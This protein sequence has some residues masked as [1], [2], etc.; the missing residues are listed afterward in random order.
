[1]KMK[2]IGAQ[3]STSRRNL[4]LGMFLIT[5]SM[6][7]V[8][9]VIDANN[10]TEEFLVAAKPATSGSI[11]TE[12]SFRIARMNLGESSRLYL[13]PGDLE[14]GNYLLNTMAVGQLVAL[15]SVASAVIDARQPVVISSTMP[16]PQGVGVGDFVDI[17]VSE[18]QEGGVFA[19]PMTLV[20]DAEIVDIAQATGV[21][22][23]QQPQVQV[24]VPVESVSPILDAVASKD[25]ISMILKRNLGND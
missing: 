25:A 12:S 20:L 23:E 5:I 14:P 3:R 17:W 18:S 1:M 9:W 16:L 22:A 11:I 19:A 24:L 6:V 8:W 15:G 2:R 10:T 4:I 7:G 21:M 13:K